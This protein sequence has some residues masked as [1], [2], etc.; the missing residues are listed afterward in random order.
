[1]VKKISIIGAGAVGSTLA[2]NLL[3]RFNLAELVL[4]DLAEDLAKGISLD[5]EDTRQFLGFPTR[6][7]AG[8]DISLIKDSAIVV[9]TAGIAR[10]EGMTR[11]DLININAKV[12]R[13]VSAGIKQYAPDCIVVA[14]TN[15]LDI[16]TYVMFKETGFMRNRIFGMG[17]SLDT[18]RMINILHN[19]TKTA[20][21]SLNG[22]VFGLH[23]NDMIVSPER[24]CVGQEKL[25]KVIS[26]G[27]ID[28]LVKRVKMRG[29][30]IVGLLK[31]RSA[32]FAPALS[33]CR[34][35][36]AIVNN[37]NE[38]IPVSVVLQGEYG[39]TD[40]CIGVPCWI[41][42]TGIDKIIILELNSQEKQALV[43]AKNFFN[44][45]TI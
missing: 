27:Q 15:P 17:A 11:Q 4:I 44:E 1:M 35:L 42:Q 16:I 43:N 10:K 33:C 45:C 32:S 8:K 7:T 19:E 22:F 28:A 25:D 20:V 39:L 29:G 2:F 24:I 3:S 37:R 12:A 26:A 40:V 6:I 9:M 14:V 13:E 23:N 36:E 18:A 38:I 30:E 41:N 31:T 34:L 5:L 21:N